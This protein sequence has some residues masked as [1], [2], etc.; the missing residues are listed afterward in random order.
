M[1]N[2]DPTISD[3][4][5]SQLQTYDNNA[6]P[7]LHLRIQR[8]K[9]P[10]LDKDFIERSRIT[11]ASG[12][13]DSDIAVCHPYFGKDDEDIWVSYIRNGHLH[14]KQAHN[15]EILGKTEWHDYSIDVS[16]E[17]C[18]IAF[19]STIKRNAR[20][21]TE[22]ITERV[23]WVFWVDDGALKA[24]MCTPLGGMVHELALENV[25]DVSAVRGPS[26]EH[27]VWD[28]GLTVFF[29]MNG[30]LYYRQLIDGVWYD[31]E[32][33]QFSGLSGLNIVKIKAF[34]TWDYRVGLQLLTDDGDLYEF[35]SFTEGLGTRFTEH[36]GFGFVEN[37]MSVSLLRVGDSYFKNHD[38]H[39]RFGL[40]DS[41]FYNYS[42]DTE[43]P[44]E[45]H[46]IADPNG[47]WGTTIEVR[48]SEKSTGA[49]NTAFTMTDGGG[50][51]YN[52]TSVVYHKRFIRLTF[53]DFNTATGDLTVTYTPGTLATPVA[54]VDGFTITFSPENLG[55]YVPPVAEVDSI[56]NND[57]EK[58][59]IVTFDRELYN[60]TDDISAHL[61]VYANTYDFYP[62]YPSASQKRVE[63]A[64][65]S[66]RA[67]S[68][69]DY[70]I[71]I[72]LTDSMK[73]TVGDIGI[74]YD[75]L[76]GLEGE[77]GYVD[78]FDETFTPTG[79][80]W[81]ISP[82]DIEHTEFGFVENSMSVTLTRIYYS[83][84]QAP[85]EHTEFGFV[86]MTPVTLTH[87]GEI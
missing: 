67:V 51:T 76:G 4:L 72:V 47:N 27:G 17:A 29:L 25:T 77:N 62:D 52:C 2:I 43:I 16:A 59:I 7:E 58:S 8:N 84:Y 54:D 83:D 53:P 10:L 11:K 9:I 86:S 24:K 55:T 75:G 60:A 65:S 34:N 3:R 23:P 63:L 32:L 15:M 78:A 22:F 1:R 39:T 13:T 85:S 61:T 30:Y 49:L 35:M 64:I 69:D 70:S 74:I 36:T 46:N 12:I 31:A 26:G 40:D 68:G 50:H 87:V 38:E 5:N 79:L 19:N 56:A 28:F 33:I 42:I 41:E 21:I 44:K 14:V 82:N 45:A 73:G 66:T 20:G 71:E 81:F 37:S 48:M 57:E 18:A 80:P 6:N